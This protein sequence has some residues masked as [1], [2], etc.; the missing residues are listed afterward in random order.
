MNLKK[1]LA[2][3]VGPVGSALLGIITLPLITWFYSIEDVG[4]IS[5]LQVVV[6][7]ST[8]LFCLGLD[9]AFV[10]EYHEEDNK[11]SLFKHSTMLPISIFLLICS[12]ALIYDSSLISKL[13]YSYE[14]KKLSV[15]TFFCCLFALA[16]RFLS[17]I[18]RMEER[19]FAYSMSQV[20]P[21]LFFVTFVLMNVWFFQSKSLDSLMFAY[22]ISFF[23]VFVIYCINNRKV[24]CQSFF[25]RGNIEKQKQLLAF[26]AP[27][28]IGGLAAW[29]LRVM[30]RMFLRAFSDF[31]EL[32]LFSVAMSLAGAATIF[33]SIF[34]T[35]WAPMVYKWIKDGE[36]LQK[37]DNISNN[38]LALVFFVFCFSSLLS[39]ILPIFLPSEYDRITSLF[40]TCL[41]GPLFYVLSESYSL[42]INV[43]RKTSYSM[44][45]SLFALVVNFIGN[46][47]LVP[48][49][50]AKGAALSTAVAFLIFM[51]L[52][53]E[54]SFHLWREFPRAKLY[55]VSISLFMLAVF[56]VVFPNY[57]VVLG[58]VYFF[59][60]IFVFKHNI[61][62]FYLYVKGK[63]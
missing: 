23:S 9:Q 4:R 24:V 16:S 10:R 13:L 36:E 63:F 27:L 18:L 49:F 48:E 32:G 22:L 3:A 56:S 15:F 5:M 33:G 52:R 42:G 29:G 43:M 40:V 57:L 53:V 44:F 59:V 61:S 6:S 25:E 20:L 1:I 31:S 62:C 50:G 60:G 45:I 47:F 7:F 37:V 12:I 2:Y 30:D 17:L 14:D 35:I 55:I 21:K 54:C 39:W 46:Y 51:I 19:A 41:S 11:A 8:L 28:I 58:G 38:M 26:G 34:T